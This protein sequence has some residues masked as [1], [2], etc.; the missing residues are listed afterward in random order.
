MIQTDKI[1]T[2]KDPK[3]ERITI[4]EAKQRNRANYAHLHEAPAHEDHDD[5]E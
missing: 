4:E 2:L 3:G 1:R 5:S